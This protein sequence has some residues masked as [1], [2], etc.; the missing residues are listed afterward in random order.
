MAIT[1][2]QRHRQE[3][4]DRD[5][6]TTLWF[7]QCG[8]GEDIEEVREAF[9][10]EI[11][12]TY[13]N[14]ALYDIRIDFET[15]TLYFA[16]AVYKY[17]A[18]ESNNQIQEPEGYVL[19]VDINSQTQH[20]TT[21]IA[22]KSFAKSGVTLEDVKNVIG[23]DGQKVNGVDVEFGVLQFS[24]QKNIYTTSAVAYLTTL[25]SLVGKVNSASFMGF[26][27]KSVLFMGA[28]GRRVSPTIYSMTFR[29]AVSPN[30]TSSFNVGEIVVQGKYGW[31]YMDVRMEDTAGTAA[32]FKFRD[33]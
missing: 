8:D 9:K 22:T 14:A 19:E 29:F 5:G 7:A 3:T 32:S 17:P 15:K 24:V 26:A 16:E 10:S 30:K 23:F 1:V 4:W 25:S 31:Q 11:P 6:V 21:S 28:S 12:D 27:E 33:R 13:L 20:I 2:T 18:T